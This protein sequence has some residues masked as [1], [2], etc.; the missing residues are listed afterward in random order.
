MAMSTIEGELSDTL[1]VEEQTVLS[2]FLDGIPVQEV[3]K[4][5]NVSMRT[6]Y[7]R[8]SDIKLRLSGRDPNL[9]AGQP[10]L[11]RSY[12]GEAAM[13]VV[14]TYEVTQDR[15]PVGSGLFKSFDEIKTFIE[16]LPAGVYDVY[17]ELPQD[18]NGVRNSEYFGEFTRHENG[19]VTY[20]P[21]RSPARVE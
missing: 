11:T 21:V 1:T 20:S 19:K 15:R 18:P 13:A 6:I 14:G 9:Q 17:K 12:V 7:R 3:A 5:L 16:T 4:K 8:L 10:L 2:L